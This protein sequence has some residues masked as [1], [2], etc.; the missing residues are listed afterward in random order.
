MRLM[1]FFL[2]I[3]FAV[4]NAAP[5]AAASSTPKPTKQT[6]K[7]PVH[8]TDG[9]IRILEK[10]G[11]FVIRPDTL[12]C[13]AFPDYNKSLTKI[14]GN[15][16]IVDRIVMKEIE[17][18]LKKNGQSIYWGEEGR[19]YSGDKMQPFCRDDGKKIFFNEKMELNS[20]GKPYRLQLEARQGRLSKTPFAKVTIEREG[21]LHRLSQAE[22][23]DTYAY[24]SP[25][26]KRQ[27]EADYQHR[28]LQDSIS[29][30]VADLSAKLLVSIFERTHQ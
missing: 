2:V 15:L 18:A 12:F 27:A 29:L 24:M 13:V 11:H 17:A 30:D 4:G 19:V 6:S 3:L 21:K 20:S 26:G 1:R 23:D 28:L 14:V 16:P 10:R 22:G 5:M 7:S 25:V 8:A 9:K